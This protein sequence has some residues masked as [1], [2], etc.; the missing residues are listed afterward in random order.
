[1]P[2][3]SVGGWIATN[4]PAW[5][6]TADNN[7]AAIPNGAPEGMYGRDINN[8][9]REV[10]K[11]IARW[12]ADMYLTATHTSGNVLEFTS[13]RGDAYVFEGQCFGITI[14]GTAL[15]ANT[16]VTAKLNGLTAYPV[17]ANGT[18][19]VDGADLPVGTQIIIAY[20]GGMWQVL[21]HDCMW[22]E[23][24]ATLYTQGSNN[25]YYRSF[26]VGP[27]KF[28]TYSGQLNDYGTFGNI[29]V[30][31]TSNYTPPNIAFSGINM[32]ATALTMAST[33]NSGST[34]Y[35]ANWSGSGAQF[36]SLC[37]HYT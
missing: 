12:N 11:D 24:A 35:A 33:W 7:N 23:Y 32:I 36:N 31:P 28:T 17:L 5:S 30:S 25:T 21:S 15:T 16:A 14:A 13:T 3:H 29:L 20:I 6:T 4:T 37:V 34:V 2:T 22:G 1:M 26:A 8:W 9:G 18:R 27:L 10:M 19:S